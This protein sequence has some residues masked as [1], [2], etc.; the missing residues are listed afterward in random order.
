MY[1]A[2]L[3]SKLTQNHCSR[4]VCILILL[5]LQQDMDVETL[6]Q[7]IKQW[8][9]QDQ[10]Q[11]PAQD[12][13]LDEPESRTPRKMS[14]DTAEEPASSSSFMPDNGHLQDDDKASTS[15]GQVDI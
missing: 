14:F 6:M 1:K 9:G 4:H 7:E 10:A 15:S 12:A 2:L 5:C 11:K 13:S 8:D 3:Q